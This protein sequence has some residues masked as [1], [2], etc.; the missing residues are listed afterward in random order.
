MDS[1]T[2]REALGLL[3][4]NPDDSQAWNTLRQQLDTAGG[5]LSQ[6]ALVRLLE[7]ARNKHGER[8]EWVAFARLLEFEIRE[9]AG[10]EQEPALLHEQARVLR[11]ELLDLP[12]ALKRLER[13]LE[14]KPA[15]PE[16][17]AAVQETADKAKRWR[18]LA[19]T[20]VAE[21]EQA[22]DDVYK[23]SM[24]MRASET[25]LLY[26]GDAVEMGVVLER[27]EQALRL[28]PS[29]QRAGKLLERCYRRSEKWDEVARVLERLA[30]RSEDPTARIE[31]G[32][33]L[34]RHYVQKLDDPARAARAYLGVLKDASDHPEATAY[35][36]QLY[37]QQ[38]RW[39]DL[40]SMY[41]N[42]LANV[43]LTSRERLGDLF[44]VGM[45]CWRKLG[46]PA[47]AEPWFDHIAK[48]DPA[49][50]GMLNFYRE[51]LAEL[52]DEAR[53]IS[54]LQAAHRALEDGEEKATI[55]TELARLAE[56]QKNAQRAVEQYKGVLRHD[57]DN[58]EA[59]EALKRLYKQTEGYNALV[60]LLR[61]QLERTDPDDIPARTAI[62]RE[63]AG[64][65]RAY[66]KSDTALVSVLNQIVQLDEKIDEQDVEELRELVRLY[67]KLGRWRDLLTNQLKLAEVT[68]DVQEK[69]AL[70]RSAARRWLDQF[71]NVQNATEAYEKLRELAPEDEEARRRLEELYRKRRAWPALYRLYES[72]LPHTR[73]AA[74]LSTMRELARLAAERL[75][76]GP[77]AV[78]LYKQILE[79]DPTR[80][81]VLDALEKHAERARDWA[82]LA[83]ALER[84]VVLLDQ[85]SARL[86]VLQKLGTVYGDHLNDPAAAT[87][88]WRRVLEVQP[89]HHRALRVLRDAYLDSA[90]YDGLEELYAAQQDWEGL[91]DVYSS[92]AD[93]AKDAQAKI[94]LS[95]RAAA[96]YEQRLGQP[97]RAFRSYERI[98]SADPGDARAARAL[99]PLYEKDEKWARLPALYEVLYE[100]ADDDQDRV[101]LLERLVEVTG[102]RLADRKAAVRYARKA[103]DLMPSS[104]ATLELLERASEAAASWDSFVEAVEARLAVGRTEQTEEVAAEERKGK[105]PKRRKARPSAREEGPEDAERRRLDL[106][107]ARLYADELGR[108]DEAVTSYKRLLELDPSDAVA[109]NALEAI[110]RRED[111]RDELRWLLNLRVTHTVSDDERVRILREW[112]TLEEDVFESEGKAAEL[113][114][115]VLE[116]HPLDEVALGSLPRLLLAA[117]DAGGAAEVI[118][119]DRDRLTGADRADREVALAEIYLS[120]LGRPLEALGAAV[121]ALELSERDQRAIRVLERLL[122]T[123]QTRAQAAQVL[124]TAYAAR[125][126]PRREADALAILLE[127]AS[128]DDE[129]LQLYQRLAEVHE[130]KL[131]SDGA[132][133]DVMLKAVAEYPERL[134]LWNRVEGLAAAAGRPTDLSETFREVLRNKLPAGIEM[135]LCERAARL[136]E[137]KLG[138]PIGATPYLERVLELDPSNER[139]FARLKD[140]LTGAERWSELEALYDRASVATDDLQRRADMLIEVA[141]ICEEIID[142]PDKAI[143][144][145][146]RILELEPHHEAAIAALDRLYAQRGR[147]EDLAELLERRLDT[148]QDQEVMELRLRLARIQLQQL[149]QPERALAHV[150]RVLR[151]RPNDYTG[152][153]LGEQLLEI[154]SLRGRAAVMLEAVYE[155]RGEIR[156]LVRVL[157]IRLEELERKMEAQGG[158]DPALEDEHKQLLRRVATLRDDRLH[159]DEGAL[160]VLTRLVPLDPVDA[161]ARDR[162]LEIGRRVGAHARV[163]EVLTQSAERADTPGLKGEILMRVARIYQQLLSDQARAEQIYRRILELDENDAEL[164]LPAARALEK[165]YLAADQ[166]DRLADMLRVQVR[167]EQDPATRSELLG[168]LGELC[169]AIL[170]DTDGAIEAWRARAE[171][172]P[173]DAVALEALDRLYEQGGRWREL[174]E[175]LARRRDIA[176]DEALRR[177]L[178]VR[179]ASTLSER[180]QSVPE[181]IDAWIAVIDEFGAERESL[182]ALEGLYRMAQ[183][184]E[185]LAETY[186]RHLDITEDSGRRLDLQAKLGDLRREHLADLPGALEAYRTALTLDARH[187]PSRE[188]LRQMLEVDDLL[189]RREA[190]EVLRPIYEA[191]GDHAQLLRVLEIEVEAGDDLDRRLEVLEKAMDVADALVGDQRRAFDY[192]QR[193]ARAAAGHTD[194]GPWLQHLERLSAAT[195]RH[196]EYVE[197]LREIVPEI[198][199][200]EVQMAVTVRIAELARHKLADQEL[201]RDY[202]TRALDL[203]ADDRTALMAL[204]SLYEETGDAQRL[205]EIL[206]RR[207]DVA[208]DAAEKK[209]LL[210]RRARLLAV[211]LQENSRAIEAYESILDLELD[212]TAVGALETLYEQEQRWN[213]LV[214]L[215][216]RRLAAGPDDSS[217]LRV[218][219]A[220]TSAQRLNDVPRAFDELERALEHDRQH[221]GAIAEL[222]RL[223]KA[224]AEAEYRARAATLLEP[225]YLVRGDYRRLMDAIG[226]RLEYSQDPVERREL[227][228]RLAQLHEEQQEDY[229][230]ALETT[231][232]LLHEDI[233]DQNTIAELERLAKVAGAE[234]RLAEVYAAEL[235]D[236]VA[237][238]PSTA[239]LARRTGELFTQL[240]DN[241]RALEFLR[242]ALAFEPDSQSLF[243][244]IDAILSQ[245]ER[246]QERVE[247][248]RQ[249]LDYRFDPPAR[250][251]TLHTIAELERFKLGRVDEAIDTYRT[252]LDIDEM[253]GRALEALT[254]LYR[255]RERWEDLS[256]LY[257]RRAESATLPE[258]AA[259]HRLSLAR[260]LRKELANTDRA[261]DQLDEIVRA[262]PTH[263]EAIRELESL[264]SEPAHKERVIEILRPLYEAQDNWRNTIRLNEERFALAE[265]PADKVLVLRETAVLWEERGRDPHRARRALRIAFELEPEDPEVRLAY[266]RLVAA[267]EAWEELAE[268]YES[269]LESEPEVASKRD[270]LTK[271]AQVHDDCRDDPRA[272]LDAFARLY[273]VEPSELEP[274]E[275]MEEI[276]M[277]LG[278]WPTV[279]RAL[280]AKVDLLLEDEERASVWRRVGEA[281]RDMLDDP[282]GAIEAY[283]HA[284][285]LDPASAFTVD[286]LIELYERQN[287]FERLVELYQRR[288]ELADEEDTELKYSLLMAAARC[289]EEKLE[290]RIRAIDVLGQALVVQPGDRDV[291]VALNR[292]YRLEQ[293]WPD[294]LDNLRLE[295][296]TA[297]SAAERVQ[298]RRQ[299][300]EIL[301]GKLESFDEALEAYR[302]VLDEVP[303]DE[304]SVLAVRAIAAEHEELRQN[305]AEILVPVLRSVGKYQ[306]LA[307]VLEMR[308]TVETEPIQRAETLRTIAEVLETQ[309]GEPGEAQQA[310]LRALAERPDAEELHADIERLAA[311]GG[312]WE[313]YADA[314]AE[315]A[316][317]TFDPEIGR[318]LYV[319]LGRIAEEKLRDDQRAIDAFVRA[320]EQAGEEPALLETLDR[321][322][323]RTGDMQA[324]SEILER[325][326]AVEDTDAAHAELHYRLALLQIHEF[327]E[328]ARGLASLRVTLERAPDHESAARELEQLTDDREL[329]EE[330]AEILETVYRLR[331]QTERLAALYEKRVR[332]A[333]TPSE[334]LEMRRSLA[335]VLEEDCGDPGAA[336]RAL[337]QGLAED[338]TDETV[339]QEL[340]RLAPITGDWKGA[341]EA[342]SEAV[343]ARRAD[344]V[345]EAARDLCVR[346]AAWL[347]DRANDWVASEQALLKA[348]EFD[349]GSDEVL[350][351]LEQLQRGPGRERELV[352]TLRRR[353]RL[354]LDEEH[355][356]GLYQQAKELAD[357]LVDAQLAEAVLRELLE[358]DDSNLWA[359]GELTQLREAAGDYQETFDLL[360]RRAELRAGGA[361]IRELRHKAGSIACE[362][363][364]Q[365]DRA[366]ELYE[367]LFDDD[368][369]DDVASAAL[370][371]LYQA[372]G[373]ADDLARLLERLIDLAES[374]EGRASLRIEL[375][376]L[377]ERQ[378]LFD[379]AIDLLRAVLDEQPG[380]SKA[381]VALSAL[382]ERTGRDEELAELLSAQIA[383]A[384]ER[385]DVEAELAFRVRLGEVYE[386]RLQDRAGA[387]QTYQDVLRRDSRHRAALEA[388]ARL[389]QADDNQTDAAKTLERLLEM[390]EGEDALRWANALAD[391]YTRLEQPE[392]VA[393][394][395]ELGLHVDQR[396]SELRTRLRRVYQAQQAWDKLAWLL[397]GEADLVEELP[398]QVKLLR[399]AANIHSLK[400]GDHASAAVLL[401]K[402]SARAPDDRELLLQLCDAYSASRRGDAAAEVLE[403]IVESYGARR[404]KD[405]GE[406]HRRLAEAYL[407]QGE[408][409]RALGELDKA[410]RIEPGNVYVLK[411]LGEVALEVGDA[412]KAQQMFRALL[413]QRLDESSPITKAEV[414]LNLGEVHAQ[415]GEKP[416]AIQMF[417]RALQADASLERAKQR[418]AELRGG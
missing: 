256:E 366:I 410:F 173:Q 395:L 9:A 417:E 191:D 146:E 262:L 94:E 345:T 37:E 141:L 135:E 299:T 153:E 199:D 120:N 128:D 354:Q 2:I 389:F 334:R 3:Q 148:A 301:A 370:K 221:Q 152:R 323:T 211:A 82:T 308:L 189:A 286:C 84:R 23:S 329:F 231:A 236:K 147:H 64:V 205:L 317:A 59:R 157:V 67:E 28:D 209:Q 170:G 50:P 18:Q 246:H 352:E 355:R 241:D 90:D 304:Q 214:A 207:V 347:R 168:S 130:S 298:L 58:E 68:P 350:E 106:K 92:A 201:A 217:A 114:R 341:A 74:R 411:R 101:D 185:Q 275:K 79:E 198:F 62:L 160:E 208:E 167:L 212:P 281:R 307:E 394:A 138:D 197:L 333:E 107:L 280:T 285:E 353:A 215:Y 332:F 45:L 387:I 312:R 263:A 357:G 14:L 239:A 261:I 362:K 81:E 374:P 351:L 31:A 321:L 320:V 171:E 373:R 235:A 6:A 83:E 113:Y 376:E 363:L 378:Q 40:V 110:L 66:I 150:E 412:K 200:G 327:R 324:L 71:T 322:Y 234:R 32:V 359:L 396:N 87:G 399:E 24:L 274:L 19:D 53:L 70:Y 156:D 229:A 240:G 392:N 372:T 244:A 384:E 145:Y 416:K 418:L 269:V 415:L 289:F 112:A 116:F 52:G 85:D 393:R 340:E 47:D 216:E 316:Q 73:G 278:D 224:A 253:D 183:R 336:Q 226:A 381:V 360:V 227:L 155:A 222:E 344:L 51:Y 390:S 406:I 93:R 318:E 69:I 349:P 57:P 177:A 382:Y 55:A 61:Q 260:L 54:V 414:F 251:A 132:A 413:L 309:L 293:M 133:L 328:P 220:T 203:R 154:G 97:D 75:N 4:E 233:A 319:R 102:T 232:L 335:R 408:T 210:F 377:N 367:A 22:P 337:Q 140:I 188:A 103:Y 388:L 291:L 338:P 108:V 16:A 10:T 380:H 136:H 276:G 255:E 282:R 383:A 165:I 371:E 271:L 15:D 178:M 181:A 267:T 402:A 296:S 42:R 169:Q 204:E 375:A 166:H 283:E 26:A 405:L 134:E 358:Y 60:E 407:V 356:E 404:S 303:S 175:V 325:R 315:R 302:L 342:L 294:L 330:A 179:S 88:A 104:E 288:V 159:D 193:A 403:K 117:G 243:D 250:L 121:R 124:A 252:A 247:L 248:Y 12:G 65:Y 5:D 63:V 365:N 242:S 279:V 176:E 49:H 245:E 195:E 292:L 1:Q 41:R 287:D 119:K 331:G 346:V 72:E 122:E 219:I 306:E 99:I 98:L 125:G 161:D 249:A 237:D 77:E 190:A 100:R 258:S 13:V 401:E 21:A 95:Y 33:R 162:L 391:A 91:A 339:L 400:L 409:E 142:A 139:A 115:R 89:G 17:T 20:Y 38:E 144:Y 277:L 398:Q 385:A 118:E 272:A 225:V 192:A 326:A 259:A 297:E 43:D 29:N 44:Q 361:V 109:A 56:G 265:E 8:G 290:D 311:A 230:A 266:E 194:L 25:Q 295:A 223:L 149:H 143:T 343:E 46:R 264:I 48:L 257:L 300:G 313:A 213:D 238:D 386:S 174:V 34:A 123:E 206:E 27:L 187:A 35:L 310:L 137:D 7:A 196:A 151:E 30:D 96:V 273:E 39:A 76:R 126:E 80:T 284:L 127:A 228:C 379:S 164:A 11:D 111:R 364:G 369:L 163:A 368:P 184:W 218:K 348:L 131:D 397:A 254:E 202:Y 78:R 105:R 86:A 172:N 186:Q 314:L 180:L 182:E 158:E 305:V 270:I 36:S 268:T 129:R